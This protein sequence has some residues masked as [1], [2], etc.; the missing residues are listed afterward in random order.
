V[1]K[2]QSGEEAKRADKSRSGEINMGG[3]FVMKRVG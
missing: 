1:A 3:W 2:W